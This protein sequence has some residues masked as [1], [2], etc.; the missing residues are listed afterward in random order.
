MRWNAPWAQWYENYYRALNGLGAIHSTDPNTGIRWIQVPAG[1]IVVSARVGRRTVENAFTNPRPILVAETVVTRAQWLRGSQ[2][3]R[4]RRD[5]TISPPVAQAVAAAAA[6]PSGSGDPIAEMLRSGQGGTSQ[7]LQRGSGRYGQ[8]T[9]ADR[10][11]RGAGATFAPVV[12]NPAPTDLRLN[13]GSHQ[14]NRD[15]NMPA[16]NVTFFEAAEFCKRIGARMPTRDEWAFAAMAGQDRPNPYGPIEEIAWFA[17]N[18]GLSDLYLH[19]I[20]YGVWENHIAPA[21]SRGAAI[22]KNDLLDSIAGD[23]EIPDFVFDDIEDASR[24]QL[25]EVEQWY[26]RIR[27]TGS[28]RAY[29]EPFMHPV[30]QKRPNQLGLFDM[31]GNVWQW[32]V[33][34]SGTSTSHPSALIV[35]GSFQTEADEMEFVNIAQRG[36]WLDWA[37]PGIGFRPVK[38]IQPRP[39]TR[40]ELLEI[41]SEAERA[42]APPAPIPA[43]RLNRPLEIAEPESEQLQPLTPAAERYISAQRVQVM[44]EL[45][46]EAPPEPAAPAAPAVSERVKMLDLDDPASPPPEQLTPEQEEA[47]KKAEEEAKKRDRIRQIEFDGLPSRY[48][49][50]MGYRS[51]TRRYYGRNRRR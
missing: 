32:T 13:V 20:H 43:E 27:A 41:M 21:R 4:S 7:I 23:E 28:T 40:T 30:A 19:F 33:T 38:D 6:T 9:D 11:R 8:Q 25:A 35:G 42:P 24:E 3:A 45:E 50:R 26:A 10:A 39:P 29:V 49:G 51:R 16:D 44:A 18:S 48:R 46:R 36:Q 1:T 34:A 37:S 2:L 31:L 5:A 14:D 12:D 17:E 15:P 47:K 22:T